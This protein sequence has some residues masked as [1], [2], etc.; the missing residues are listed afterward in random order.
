[1][2]Q[3]RTWREVKVGTFYDNTWHDADGAE[4]EVVNPATEQ[5]FA[6]VFESSERDVDA[7]VR[8]AREALNSPE[9]A[10]LDLEARCAMVSRVADIVEDRAEELAELRTASMGSPWRSSVTLSNSVGLIRTFVAAARNLRLREVRRGP[11]GSGLL[12]RRPVGVVAG[13]VP[14]NVPVRNELKKLVP[15]VLA[16]NTIVLKGAPQ[17]PLTGAAL[18]DIFREAGFPPGVVNLV[19]G[20]TRVGQQL[21]E[22]PDVAKVSFTGSTPAGANIGAVAGGR[23][24]RVQLELG[25]KSAAILLEDADL[26]TAIPQLLAFGFGN[27]GQ[28]CASLSR[29]VVPREL[30]DEVVERLVAGARAHVLGDPRDENT[31]LGPVVTRDQQDRVLGLVERAAADGARIATGGKRPEEPSTG[32]FVEPTVV[33]DVRSDMEIAQEEIFGPVISVLPYDDVDDAVRIAND[34]K[35]GLH[36]AVFGKDPSRA[37]AVGERVETGTLAVNGFDI[38]F[39]LP[40]GGVKCSGIGRENGLEGFT[41]YLEMRSYKLPPEVADDLVRE[42]PSLDAGEYG[43]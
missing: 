38:P 26:D 30:Q 19:T 36:G 28:I 42:D 14:W 3:D 29:I 12:V 35:Y 8:S 2:G 27:S 4:I 11:A 39:N 6:S 41:S 18:M 5:G 23:F 31:T 24:A 1:M 32:W 15:A 43:A 33:A 7:A 17:S 16:G 25:G 40:F 21:V 34:S 9:W 22:H 20:G 37:L 10:D 13:I